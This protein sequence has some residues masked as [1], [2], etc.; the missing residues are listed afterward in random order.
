MRLVSSVGVIVHG[1]DF[2][3]Q[4]LQEGDQPVGARVG[5]REEDEDPA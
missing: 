4:A 5:P 3:S 1:D 2:E